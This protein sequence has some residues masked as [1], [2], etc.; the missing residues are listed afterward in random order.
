MKRLNNK[1]LTKLISVFLLLIGF[2]YF[3]IQFTFNGEVDDLLRNEFEYISSIVGKSGMAMYNSDEQTLLALNA[4][5]PSF[6]KKTNNNNF[7]NSEVDFPTASNL[8][9]LEASRRKIT[10]IN[11]G[12]A[13]SKNEVN[14]SYIEK[15]LNTDY[16]TGIKN[17]SNKTSIIQ[18]DNSIHSIGSG[19]QFDAVSDN[20]FQSIPNNSNNSFLANNSL[21]LTTDLSGNNSPMMID[22]GSNPGDPGV[23]VGDGTWALIVMMLAYCSKGFRPFKSTI[24]S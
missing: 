19:V 6:N 11:S 8:Q 5:Y 12:S 22:G 17:V 14:Y 20:K 23:P 13:N 10:P 7:S 3:S 1:R 24:S 16:A 4:N 18:S 21:S 2:L 9:T 15:K